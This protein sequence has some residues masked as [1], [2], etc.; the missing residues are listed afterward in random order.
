MFCNSKSYR[1]ERYKYWGLK[2]RSN[3]VA[4]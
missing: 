3:A 4:R 2:R 1:S